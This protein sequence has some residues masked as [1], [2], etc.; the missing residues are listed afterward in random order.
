MVMKFLLVHLFNQVKI[1]IIDDCV[2]YLFSWAEWNKNPTV[3]NRLFHDESFL[4]LTC[5]ITVKNRQYYL[6]I[7]DTLDDER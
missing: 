4:K 1:R 2:D 3:P 6:G 5:L 7:R